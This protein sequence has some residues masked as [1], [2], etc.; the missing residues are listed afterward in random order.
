MPIK[1]V[2]SP[3]STGQKPKPQQPP[4]PPG[5]KQAAIYGDRRSDQS[6]QPPPIPPPNLGAR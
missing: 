6:N 1:E 3:N 2:C 5:V 4:A